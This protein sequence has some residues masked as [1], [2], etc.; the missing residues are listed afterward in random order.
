MQVAQT[1][2][3]YSKPKFIICFVAVVAVLAGISHVFNLTPIDEAQLHA[4]TE[5][6]PKRA[7]ADAVD[8]ATQDVAAGLTET[9]IADAEDIEPDDEEDALEEDD[10]TDDGA[11][12]TSPLSDSA[13][14]SSVFVSAKVWSYP[15]CFPDSN[16]LQLAAARLN[17]VPPM[18]S[19][20]ELTQMLNQQRL[21]CISSSPYYII[22]EL[23]HSMPYLVPKAQLLLNTIGINF[24]DSLHSKGLAL[25][26]PI[27]TSVLRT[28]DDIR[29]LQH[30][31]SNSVTNSC[32]CYGTTI[33]ITYNRFM[34]LAGHT[35]T[36]Y[37]DTL[38]K[39]LAEVLFDLRAQGRCYVKYERK[40]ACFHLTVI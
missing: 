22:D 16:A 26:L 21:S 3:T 40:Q 18:Q 19:R 28:S 4:K 37:D 8:E 11:D 23:T 10:K 24:V 38:K 29:S 33:D 17:G 12:M 39:V 32:H 30:G 31:N 5:Q 35:P 13:Y 6:P 7:T 2:N 9:E 25:H 20:S 34:P 15:L 14:V 36:R 1:N 27:V